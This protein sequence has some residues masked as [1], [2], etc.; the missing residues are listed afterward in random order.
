MSLN[1]AAP[2]SLPPPTWSTPALSGSV[3]SPGSRRLDGAHRAFIRTQPS[4]NASLD[5]LLP[6]GGWPLGSLVEILIERAGEAELGLVLP[7]LAAF[8]RSGRRVAMIAP[9]F[10]PD[11]SALETAGVDLKR[12]IQID[13]DDAELHWS[14]EQSLRAG[15][16]ASVLHWL[17]EHDYRKLRRLQLAAEAGGSLAFVFGSVQAARQ[18]SPAALRLR[19]VNYAGGPRIEVIKCRGILDQPQDQRISVPTGSQKSVDRSGHFRAEQAAGGSL[20]PDLG[21]AVQ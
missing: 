15:C 2:L 7:A 10:I 5:T 13:A 4:G 1:F 14:A 21:M 19:L 12:L 18:S 6:G 9:P 17:P 11:P 8:T 16:C 20:R 3:G